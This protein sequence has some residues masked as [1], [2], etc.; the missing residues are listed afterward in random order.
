M[1][2]FA[3]CI[4][5]YLQGPDGFVFWVIFDHELL[6]VVLC[7]SGSSFT[8]WIN[9]GTYGTRQKPFFWLRYGLVFFFVDSIENEEG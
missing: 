5:Y 7:I 6:F 1:L 8:P 9:Y 4:A 3:A 2:V